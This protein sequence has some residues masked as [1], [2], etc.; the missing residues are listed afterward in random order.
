MTKKATY[1]L[2][3]GEPG[4]GKSS[5]MPDPYPRVSREEVA[6]IIDPLPW[7]DDWIGMPTTREFRRSESLART[8][9]ILALLSRGE[10]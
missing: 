8:D 6:R 10:G 4:I 9:A 2:A 7:A 1:P 5:T 3:F